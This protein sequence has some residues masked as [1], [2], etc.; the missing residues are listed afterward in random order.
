MKCRV[1][2]RYFFLFRTIFVKRNCRRGSNSGIYI[3][4]VNMYKYKTQYTQKQR[5]LKLH[6]QSDSASLKHQVY[7]RR[8][9]LSLG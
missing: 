8:V 5:G 4:K 1:V 9:R 7:E 2:P 6:Y 3:L